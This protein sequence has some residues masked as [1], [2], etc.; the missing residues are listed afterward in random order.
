MALKMGSKWVPNR[1]FDAEALRKPLRRLLEGSWSRTKGSWERLLASLGLKRESKEEATLN[2]KTL[3][4][5]FRSPR[6]SKRLP[7]SHFRFVWI[8]F[9]THLDPIWDPLCFHFGLLAHRQHEYVGELR[10]PTESSRDLLES[11]RSYNVSA[12]GMLSARWPASGA[13]PPVRY[14]QID[15]ITL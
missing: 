15:F 6:G 7:A 12:S 3:Q 1:I 11:I 14:Y 8:P 10:I 2:P 4:D 13:Q 5:G 9:C